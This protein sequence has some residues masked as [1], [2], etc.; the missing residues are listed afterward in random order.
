VATA[1]CVAHA[2]ALLHDFADSH[3]GPSDLVT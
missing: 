2:E 3:G 1:I